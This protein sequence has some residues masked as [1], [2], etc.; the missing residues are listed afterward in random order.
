MKRKQI[1]TA[2]LCGLLGTGMVLTGCSAGTTDEKEQTSQDQSTADDAFKE[3]RTVMTD[4]GE[5]E[6]PVHPEKCASPFSVN[7]SSLFSPGLIYLQMPFTDKRELIQ[8]I[9]DQLEEHGFALPGLFQS[10][11][12][13]EKTTSTSIS[14]GIAFPHGAPEF[15]NESRIVLVTL[16]KPIQW[17]EQ[18]SADIIFFAC[19]NMTSQQER[20]QIASFYKELIPSISTPGFLEKLR[21]EKDSIRLYQYL[22]G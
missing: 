13:R 15:V 10:A 5:V 16:Q 21:E 18:D 14:G 6:I 17:D 19:F 3:T 20:R 2:V 22:C 7:S 12:N 4:K 9:T 11:I 8:F 1:M